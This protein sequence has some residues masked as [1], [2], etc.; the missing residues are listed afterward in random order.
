MSY[1]LWTPDSRGHR[2]QP[3]PQP[4]YNLQNFLLIKSLIFT[5]SLTLICCRRCLLLR[6]HGPCCRSWGYNWGDSI[7]GSH[8]KEGLLW[9]GAFLRLI[10]A[11][12]NL[13]NGLVCSLRTV[14][15]MIFSVKFHSP[16]PSLLWVSVCVCVCVQIRFRCGLGVFAARSMS[17]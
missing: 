5:E 13:E 10:L 3:D 6:S 15:K 8:I 1:P 9:C 7:S 12:S 14:Q 11:Q 17:P 4:R 2:Q 16:E